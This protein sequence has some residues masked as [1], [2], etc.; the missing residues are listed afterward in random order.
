MADNTV[1]L[2][3]AGAV[4]VLN[5][6]PSDPRKRIATLSDITNS[7]VYFLGFDNIYVED[8]DTHYTITGGDATN[9]W[10]FTESGGGGASFTNTAEEFTAALED[11]EI[12]T[13]VL[14][15][16]FA[17]A[18][19]ETVL[20]GNK[21]ILGET[22]ILQ[23]LIF[24]GDN[25][26]KI[27]FHNTVYI[28]DGT[29]L[30]VSS[31]ASVDIYFSYVNSG[32]G[33]STLAGIGGATCYYEKLY[34]GSNTSL[35]ISTSGAVSKKIWK[36]SAYNAM[37]ARIETTEDFAYAMNDRSVHT[38]IIDAANGLVFN[39]GTFQ[40][41][42]HPNKTIIGDEIIINGNTT[43]ETTGGVDIRF[44]NEFYISPNA[45]FTLDRQKSAKNLFAKIYGK[46]FSNTGFPNTV[47]G[48][49]V[50][51]HGSLIYEEISDAVN[52]QTGASGS[53][54]KD[55]WTPYNSTYNCA[56][57]TAQDLIYA[58]KSRYYEI[59]KIERDIVLDNLMEEIALSTKKTIVGQDLTL[60]FTT[61]DLV[62]GFD[63]K[64]HNNIKCVNNSNMTEQL[65]FRNVD[66]SSGAIFNIGN[67]AVYEKV[68]G[69]GSLENADGNPATQEY[70]DNTG[71]TSQEG[72][73]VSTLP[74]GEI[75]Q[76][77]YVTDSTSPTFRGVVVGG[78]SDFTPVIFD[79]ANWICA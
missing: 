32:D 15:K 22:I 31:D 71:G 68:T 49:F 79:G 11:P 28:A 72:F 21:V 34:R 74:T 38:L 61:L 47:D 63:V 6:T 18:G 2:Q 29:A 62:G 77:A 35:A 37:I 69:S 24:I 12:G 13:I 57:N 67:D 78:G 46:T 14:G 51:E 53:I 43:W 30:F 73:T 56:V 36:N 48:N 52:L 20:S 54:F 65:Y 59:I 66:V 60:D 58:L 9:G 26:A 55:A 45:T 40:F 76:R 23:A 25:D 17:Y 16:E 50:M 4:E 41:E 3:L 44:F 64:F 39:G 19:T 5:P 33:A 42:I 1:S 10:E 8:E 7:P 70:W 75:G 27:E